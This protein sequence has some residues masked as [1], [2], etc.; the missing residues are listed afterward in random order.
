MVI[1][2]TPA[3]LPESGIGNSCFRFQTGPQEGALHIQLGSDMFWR[4]A[5]QDESISADRQHGIGV[6]I[7]IGK[8]DFISRAVSS[9]NHRIDLSTAQQ[10]SLTSLNVVCQSILKE[11]D[12]CM[13]VNGIA[14]CL[15]C[16]RG[17]YKGKVFSM[18]NNPYTE[19]ESGPLGCCQRKA[20]CVHGTEAIVALFFCLVGN[21]VHAIE[22]L[23]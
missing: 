16:I 8:L 7:S 19:D 21:C 1:V 22:R 6:A 23:P 13:Q 12:N 11:R 3:S 10:D 17:S 2:S 18:T 15:C 14:H 4:V 9:H 20:Y 5:A